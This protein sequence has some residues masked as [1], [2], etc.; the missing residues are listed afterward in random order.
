[1]EFD[2][3][4]PHRIVD[5][6]PVLMTADEIAA[7]AAE[8]AALAPLV[9]AQQAEASRLAQIDATISGASFNGGTT[10]AQLKAMSRD[11]FNAWWAA[12]VTNAAQ[13]IAVL[14]FIAWQVLRR[15]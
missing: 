11:Q 9:A 3:T 15:L 4:Q 6:V 1:M 8:E 5:G 10:L 12:N 2:Y 14:K 13:A 7:R